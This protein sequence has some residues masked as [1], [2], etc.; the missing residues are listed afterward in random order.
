MREAIASAKG[1]VPKTPK[2]SE[3]LDTP[4]T[5]ETP[6]PDSATPKIDGPQSADN[7]AEPRRRDSARLFSE[8]PADRAGGPD[9]AAPATTT[10]S[11]STK[12][13]KPSLV[14]TWE[15]TPEER[16]LIG[17]LVL[18]EYFARASGPNVLERI[19]AG[20]RTEVMRSLLDQLGVDGMR[21]AMSPEF[22]QQLRAAVPKHKSG[23][24]DKP[25]KP[26]NKTITL[27][28]NSAQ[29]RGNPSRH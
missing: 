22:G 15:S 26:F 16:Q 17:D 27:T 14:E 23:K 3:T 20:R 4:K 2:T 21:A 19:P 13:K 29:P 6:Q 11:T 5:L 7:S 8:D 10:T 9:A 28:A 12:S 18:E 25:G 1:G 24:S